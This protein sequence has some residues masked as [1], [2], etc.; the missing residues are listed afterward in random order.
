MAIDEPDLAIAKEIPGRNFE[1]VMCGINT[2]KLHR[3]RVTHESLELGVDSVAITQLLALLGVHL[4][5]TPLA[6]TGPRPALQH[7]T[8]FTP[9]CVEILHLVPGVPLCLLDTGLEDEYLVLFGRIFRLLIPESS[10]YPLE[11]FHIIL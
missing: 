11:N 4:I 10:F 3:I 5:P 1:S 8:L 7:C 9:V 6:A 2:V